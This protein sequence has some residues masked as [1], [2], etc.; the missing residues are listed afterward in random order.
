VAEYPDR[1]RESL[2]TLSSMLLSEESLDATLKRVA[3]LACET[4]P[5]CDGC[6]VTLASE[7]GPFTK[8]ASH[9]IVAPVDHAQ[10]DA[11]TGPCLTAYRERRVI[12]V[13]S[14]ADDDRWPETG[15]VAVEVGVQSSMSFPLVVR[16]LAIGAMN[17]YSMKPDAFA[18]D[19]ERVGR[20]FAEQAAV[21][22][23]NAQT[24]AASVALASNLER[25]LE[26]RS[27]IDQAIGVMRARHGGSR[28]EGFAA[29]R[30]LSQ[31]DNVKLREVAQ[32][33]LDEAGGA[34]SDVGL[35]GE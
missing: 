26:S 14:M 6:G 28:E 15:R 22:L 4:V 31:R 2:A 25:A 11:G 5:G 9:D 33:V 19:A 21:A 30:E 20:M 18:S 8:A 27:V 29:L 23:A 7:S 34:G 24:H 13:D 32:R 35:G 10:Y 16:D 12:R 1:L 3:L 17:L